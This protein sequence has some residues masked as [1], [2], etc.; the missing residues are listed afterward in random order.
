MEWPI[1]ELGH[2]WGSVSTEVGVTYLPGSEQDF[3]AAVRT[4]DSILGVSMARDFTEVG[5][6][7]ILLVTSER[8]SNLFL[9]FGFWAIGCWRGDRALAWGLFQF[10]DS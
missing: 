5:K 9:G 10:K 6:S 2:S 8:P 3:L 7:R 1:P 4:W